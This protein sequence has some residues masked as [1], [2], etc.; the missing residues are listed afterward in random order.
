METSAPALLA[1]AAA[2]GLAPVSAHA[3]TGQSPSDRGVEELIIYGTKQDLT[4]QEVAVSVEVFDEVRIE[5]EALFS[6]DDLLLRTPNAT[7]SGTGNIAIRGI[8]RDGIGGAGQ[9]VTSNVYLDGVPIATFALSFG[10]ESLWDIEQVEV[11]RGPQST[12]QGRNALAGAIVITTKDPTYDWEVAGRARYAEFDTQQF[13]GVVSGPLV[14]DQLAFR[15][16]V[17]YQS[18]DGF[19]DDVLVDNA[20]ADFAENLL[21]RGKI[22]AEPAALPGLRAELI[23]DYN[24]TETGRS[25]SFLALP[26]PAT[27]PSFFDFDPFDRLNF[28][29]PQ[30]NDSDSLRLIG[31]LT[32]ELTDNLTLRG[33]GTFEET[34]R[35]RRLGDPDNPLS[36]NNN[37]INDDVVRTYSGELRAEY[38]FGR[39]SGSVGA[40]YFEDD[41]D[42]FFDFEVPLGPQVLFPLNPPD[43]LISGTLASVTE[44]QNFAFYG[45][46]RFDVTDRLSVSFAIRYDQEEFATTGEQVSTPALTPPDCIASVPGVI[47]GAPVPVVDVPCA[48][49]LPTSEAVPQSDTFDAI[50]PRGTITY[51]VTPGASVFFSAQ[52]GYRAGGTFVTQNAAGVTFG[53]FDPEFLTNYEIG[54]RSQWFGGQLVVNGNAFLSFLNDQQLVI[55][56]PSGS[57]LDAETV[58][59]GESTLYG[60]ELVADYSPL[61]GLHFFGSF[62]YLDAEFDDFPFALP[63]LPFDNLAGND[64]PQAPEVSFTVGGSYEHAT[65]L[66]VDASLNYTSGFESGANLENLGPTEF[67]T[68]FADLGLDPAL[69]AQLTERL[70]DRVLVN[71]RIGYRHRNFT[72]AGYVTNLFNEDAL[73]TANLAG[74]DTGTG[75]LNFFETPSFTV[76]EPQVFGVLL[77]VRF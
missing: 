29:E 36:F 28:T 56:G 6:L 43:T 26:V 19:I 24:K 58:N 62:G 3:Q 72:I 31:D 15:F 30:A 57:F 60:F 1:I 33:I 74:V 14:E 45:Q 38:R 27:D 20:N 68:A 5:R 63:G 8:D 73:L 66:F 50:L 39:W 47:V 2:A 71:A 69:G 35:F 42:L 25:T 12:V 51:N 7:T 48:A 22:L 41:Q 16:A 61:E 34:E 77:D 9:G 32:Y 49:L 55:P 54:F 10:F 53:T 52:R 67:A 76:V 59:A 37:G 18:T 64:L 46:T 11:L 44:T 65:G 23:V 70:D 75:T 13:A 40:Y 21:L 4:Y 17:D